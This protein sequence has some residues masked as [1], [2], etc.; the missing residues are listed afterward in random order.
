MTTVER[1]P[2]RRTPAVQTA[3]PE[4]P[5]RILLVEDHI[6]SA[7]AMA[8]V[9]R[10]EKHAVEWVST[11]AAAVNLFENDIGR[12]LD[13]ILLDLMLPDMNGPELVE[14]LR[15]ASPFV[16]PIVVLSAKPLQTI[17]TEANALGA[18]AHLRK[19]FGVDELLKVV[20][21]ATSPAGPRG[22]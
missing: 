22:N 21:R 16:P 12:R 10:N 13:L 17:R 5:L 15:L 2:E 19:P 14:E 7:E 4:R 6:D 18:V 8:T 1:Q 3:K 20:R 9:L 11:G